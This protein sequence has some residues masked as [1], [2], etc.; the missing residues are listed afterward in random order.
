MRDVLLYLHLTC[1]IPILIKSLTLI[2]NKRSIRV[3]KPPILYKGRAFNHM[4]IHTKMKIS[5]AQCCPHSTLRTLLLKTVLLFRTI[6]ISFTVL[7]RRT[8]TLNTESKAFLFINHML[9]ILTHTLKNTR[10]TIVLMPK[11]YHQGGILIL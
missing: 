6:P 1:M 10:L 5:G 2:T 4:A 11:T 7:T 8:L 9:K 3:T